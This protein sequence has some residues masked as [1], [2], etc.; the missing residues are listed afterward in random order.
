MQKLKIGFILC[1][2]FIVTACEHPEDARNN[3]SSNLQTSIN[4]PERPS[5]DVKRDKTRVPHKV[6]DFFNIKRGDHVL[7]LLAANGYYSELLSRC[8]GKN[9]R[10]YLQNNQKFFDFQTDK[11]VV[12]RLI[13]NRLPN[14]V[15]LDSEL[16]NIS[17]EA[18]SI[19]KLLMILVLH[20]FYWMENDVNEVLSQSYQALK[21]GGILGIIDHAAEVGSGNKHAIDMQGIHRIDKAFVIDSMLQH[22]FILDAE[23][24]ALANTNDD[25]TKA[26]FSPEL[27]GKPT[28]RFML[29]FKKPETSK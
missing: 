28:N 27:K 14:V 21:P 20:D 25:G 18:N 22:G 5:I 3:N 24:D 16:S 29:R 2:S 13:H 6:L 17:V 4:H 8:V 7:E 11:L 26:F 10:V 19:D 9:G 15:R 12:E 1:I 23:S